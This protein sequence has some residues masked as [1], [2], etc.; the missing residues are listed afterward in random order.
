[1]HIFSGL[2]ALSKSPKGA[3]GST[4]KLEN[5]K[6]LPSQYEDTSTTVHYFT[7]TLADAIWR[8]G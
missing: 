2:V 3:P 5:A 7:T 1:M 4:S 6:T 8:S